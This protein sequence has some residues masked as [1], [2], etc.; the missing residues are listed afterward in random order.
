MTGVQTCAL[1]ICKRY[2]LCARQASGRVRD[3]AAR[4]ALAPAS[5]GTPTAL[6]SSLTA[7]LRHDPCKAGSFLILQ[8]EELPGRLAWGFDLEG[9]PPFLIRPLSHRNQH[10]TFRNESAQPSPN[11]A[12]SLAS[13]LHRVRRLLARRP[14]VHQGARRKLTGGAAPVNSE[15]QERFRRVARWN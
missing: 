13:P 11:K 8:R 4:L 10:Y 2:P 9:L 15:A 14:A 1:P 6:V 3:S 5:R 7:H 12:S